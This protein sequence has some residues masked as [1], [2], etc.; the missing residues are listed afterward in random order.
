MTQYSSW[1]TNEGRG[2]M[3]GEGMTKAEGKFVLCA[4]G[5]DR[6]GS[7]CCVLCRARH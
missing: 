5:K 1:N 6:G 2:G 7:L 3:L 4:D